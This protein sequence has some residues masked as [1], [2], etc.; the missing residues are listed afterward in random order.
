MCVY[1]CVFVYVYGH[2][3]IHIYIYI[4]YIVYV[5]T[6]VATPVDGPTPC[7][8]ISWWLDQMCGPCYTDEMVMYTE[9]VKNSPQK[10]VLSYS[11]G[12]GN[13][14]SDGKWVA[15]YQIGTMFVMGTSSMKYSP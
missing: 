6:N 2:V 5:S 10:F 3:S 9:A 11:P 14:P 15:N 12:G 4:L 1:V 13:E 8:A 7:V